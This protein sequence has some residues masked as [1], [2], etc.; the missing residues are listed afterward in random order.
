[1]GFHYFIVV[2]SFVKGPH[3]KYLRRRRGEG[4][5][6]ERTKN[7]SFFFYLPLLCAKKKKDKGKKGSFFP[8]PFHSLSSLHGSNSNYDFFFLLS[9]FAPA[10]LDATKNVSSEGVDLA[11]SWGGNGSRRI[12]TQEF[13][14]GPPPP[15]PRLSACEGSSLQHL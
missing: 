1:M 6:R 3:T 8:L 15:P 7:L 11:E 14:F 10:K 9:H 2:A 12:K 4:R 5:E 13:V